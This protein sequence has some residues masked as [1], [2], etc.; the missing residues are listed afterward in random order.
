[1]SVE[2]NTTYI[3]SMKYSIKDGENTNWDAM[4]EFRNENQANNYYDAMLVKYPFHSWRI[5]EIKLTTE[6]NVVRC[7]E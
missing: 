5:E 3:V 6:H 7:K 2:S 1:M 4:G